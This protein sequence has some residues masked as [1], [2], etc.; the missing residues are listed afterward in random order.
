MEQSAL[1][2]IIGI[3]A[4]FVVL[5]ILFHHFFILIYGETPENICRMSVISHAKTQAAGSPTMNIKCPR[6]FIVIDNEGYKTYYADELPID[7]EKLKYRQ[8]FKE[9]SK[10]EQIYKLMADEMAKCWYKMGEGNLDVFSE[11]WFFIKNTCVVCAEIGFSKDFEGDL[12]TIS[13]FQEYLENNKF[14]K[15]NMEKNYFDYLYKK[16]PAS[17]SINALLYYSEED[18]LEFLADEKDEITT[19]NNYF[20]SFKGYKFTKV[21]AGVN[22]FGKKL[23]G[24]E[25]DRVFPNDRYFVFFGGQYDTVDSCGM[26]VN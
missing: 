12:G 26:M 2:K 13:E 17:F 25:L 21:T 18:S 1:V 15:Y 6:K 11:D 14:T 9:G 7:K 16:Y 5:A 4:G 10:K 20:I 24:K 3:V 23:S 22:Y 19:D 8:E